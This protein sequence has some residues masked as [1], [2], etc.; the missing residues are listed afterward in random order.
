MF[1]SFAAK[2]LICCHKLDLLQVSAYLAANHW[3]TLWT[4]WWHL[5]L[6]WLQ[7]I[8]R[9]HL[10][11]LRRWGFS[12]E[13]FLHRCYADLSRVCGGRVMSYKSLSR[14][15][16]LCALRDSLTWSAQRYRDGQ[17]YRFLHL[18]STRSVFLP[19]EYGTGYCIVRCE[20]AQFHER[21]LWAIALS[22]YGCACAGM[23]DN[24]SWEQLYTARER[25]P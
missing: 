17:G 22:R 7:S 6:W 20:R 8:W 13:L 16:Q 14:K 2:S 11:A 12:W 1:F 5:L 21:A 9:S 19:R 15:Q 4:C 18:A 10:D 24:G 23:G 25:A 3:H